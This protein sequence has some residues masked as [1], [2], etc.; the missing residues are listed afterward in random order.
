M[1]G[2]KKGRNEGR[3]EVRTYVTHPYTQRLGLNKKQDGTSNQI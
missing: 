2:K 1:K 3:E